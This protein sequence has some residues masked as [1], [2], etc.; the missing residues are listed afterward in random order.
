MTAVSVHTAAVWFGSKIVLTRSWCLLQGPASD[1]AANSVLARL[2]VVLQITQQTCRFIL[3]LN[4]VD[5]LDSSRFS[6]WNRRDATFCPQGT[7]FFFLWSMTVW[8]PCFNK[9]EKIVA[10]LTH[11]GIKKKKTNSSLV[12][13]L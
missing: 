13:S 11:F 2:D 12:K 3:S 8:R 1:W 7:V 9:K 5:P 10:P 6:S 4:L